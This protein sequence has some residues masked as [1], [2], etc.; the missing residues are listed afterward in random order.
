MRSSGCETNI[1]IPVFSLQYYIMKFHAILHD[2]TLGYILSY[3]IILC[4]T[5]IFYFIIFY[6]NRFYYTAPSKLQEMILE[7]LGKL[8]EAPA[9]V[10]VGLL[11]I[12]MLRNGILKVLGG[13]LCL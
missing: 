10:V 6:H 7:R 12:V 4:Y 1:P 2:G 11:C 3:C 8:M 13:L 9:C 5:I